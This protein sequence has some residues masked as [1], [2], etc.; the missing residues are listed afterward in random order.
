MSGGATLV[1]Q[2]HAP[3]A[4]GPWQRACLGSV[5][6]WAADRGHA[7]RFLDDALFDG[8]PGW[9]M[10]KCR[11]HGRMA[12]AADLGRLLR[13]REALEAGAD[14]VVWLDADVLV[15]DP[16]R[17]ALPD[18]V[19]HAFGVEVWVQPGADGRPKARRN[20]HNAVCLFRRGNPV[21]DFLIH[22]CLRLVEAL[23]PEKGFPPQLCGP[24][25][26]NALHP[27]VRFPLVE[28]V[29]M[30]S[31]L[32]G[33]DLI[34]R[35]DGRALDCWRRAAADLPPPAAVNLCASLHGRTV[36][37]VLCDDAYYDGIREAAA[38]LTG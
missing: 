20:V 12:T 37:G 4:L 9:Y 14:R 13:L 30:V 2:S 26:L 18:D 15:I 8:I 32:L 3:A 11:D 16:A 10:A 36:D 29:G 28:T 31:P 33:A 6:A 22:G 25:L 27:L 17:L 23:E 19:D 7:Y 1:L 21:L 34:G 5:E 38:R 35:G 24:R